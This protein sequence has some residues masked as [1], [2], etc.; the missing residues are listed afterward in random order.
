MPYSRDFSNFTII[1][2]I[3]VTEF[4]IVSRASAWTSDVGNS[5]KADDWRAGEECCDALET[6]KN[7]CSF[8]TFDIISNAFISVAWIGGGKCISVV[9]SADRFF[10]E[11]EKLFWIIGDVMT[12]TVPS[13]YQKDITF[14][15]KHSIIMWV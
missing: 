3:P 5:G 13:R 11:V 9:S 12:F 4:S 2:T 8:V 7:I 1:T 10:F 15:I 6:E 14:G